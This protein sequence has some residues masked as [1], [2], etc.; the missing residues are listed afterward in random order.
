MAGKESGFPDEIRK[1][2]EAIG[3]MIFPDVS[4]VT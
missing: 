1:D 4:V 3:F 2:G